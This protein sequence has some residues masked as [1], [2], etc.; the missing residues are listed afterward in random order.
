[1][2]E[3]IIINDRMF[4][5]VRAAAPQVSYSR[6]YITRLAREQKIR[7]VHIGRI[8]Y[9]DVDALQRYSETQKIET[10]VKNAHLRQRRQQEHAMREALLQRQRSRSSQ[11]VFSYVLTFTAA[12]LVLTFGLFAGTQ[13]Q[14]VLPSS[15]A[16]ASL[17]Q[18]VS[19]PTAE[20]IGVNG[21]VLKPVF[22]ESTANAVVD[23][24]RV[25][26]R[27]ATEKGWLRIYHD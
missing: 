16:A 22:V 24:G 7:A 23:D 15:P 8:W 6:D 20:S 27:P 18:A 17:S 3:Q 2:A 1:M 19:Q 10:S 26:A 11:H 14:T 21:V 12:C 13:L 4:T 25:V 5:A 9:V